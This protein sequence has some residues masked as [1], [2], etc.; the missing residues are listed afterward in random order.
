MSQFANFIF[1]GH[2][3][4][5]T[6]VEMQTVDR[7]PFCRLL[8]FC[9]DKSVGTVS[10]ITCIMP[11]NIPI[12]PSF[13]KPRAE[14]VFPLEDPTDFLIVRTFAEWETRFLS[15]GFSKTSPPRPSCEKNSAVFGLKRCFLFPAKRSG[16]SV[17][18][19]FFSAKRRVAARRI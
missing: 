10:A 19:W 5:V 8:C 14:W 7:R 15:E 4:D 6:T 18:E 9:R 3:V 16:V 17:G 1:R 11:L 2:R 12:F 13:K